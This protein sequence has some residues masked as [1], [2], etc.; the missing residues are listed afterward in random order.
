MDN[1]YPSSTLEVDVLKFYAR[2]IEDVIT[3]CHMWLKRKDLQT[4]PVHSDEHDH[5]DESQGISRRRFSI[6]IVAGIA[7]FGVIALVLSA[8]TLSV[9]GGEHH[10]GTQNESDVSSVSSNLIPLLEVDQMDT[11][12]EVPPRGVKVMDHPG[13]PLPRRLANTDAS[14]QSIGD[15]LGVALVPTYLPDGFVRVKTDVIPEMTSTQ[16]VFANG[17][18]FL[19]VSQDKGPYGLKVKRGQ[20]S[21]VSING[22]PGYFVTGLWA[23]TVHRDGTIDPTDWDESSPQVVFRRGDWRITVMAFGQDIV[24]QDELLRISKSIEPL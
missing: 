10:G 11:P 22:N 4:S 7:G 3:R 12:D 19:L 15:M 18:S 23:N 16:L 17:N 13:L 14:L 2:K 24:D 9:R 1:S 20:A 8:M 21:E 5:S 6:G